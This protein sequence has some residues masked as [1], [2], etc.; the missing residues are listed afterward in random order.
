MTV[1]GVDFGALDP[2]R[3]LDRL[4]PMPGNR[5]DVVIDAPT[6]ST[7]FAARAHIRGAAEIGVIGVLEAS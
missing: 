5:A 6:K 3:V 2:S 1:R 4:L 7:A